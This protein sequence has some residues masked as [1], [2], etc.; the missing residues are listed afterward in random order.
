P[1]LTIDPTFG[2]IIFTTVEP[3]GKH[4]FEKLGASGSEDYDTPA[5]YNPN[6]SRYVFRTMYR[7]TQAAALQDSEK[8]MFQL[9]GRYKSSG[10]DGIPIGAF[11]VPQGSV[12]VS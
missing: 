12:V 3:F 11:N 9:R 8:N 1:G 7:S 2:R 10:G 6:Q 4:L 5:S